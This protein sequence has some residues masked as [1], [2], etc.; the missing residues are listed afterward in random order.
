MMTV[1]ILTRLSMIT[2][3]SFGSVAFVSAGNEQPSNSAMISAEIAGITYT[4]D[5]RSIKRIKLVEGLFKGWSSGNP[6]APEKFFH[7]EGSLYDVVAGHKF[8]SWKEI[9]AFFAAEANPA[10]NL[11][12]VPERYWVSDAGVALTWIMSFTILDD[13][14]G[15]ENKGKR[16]RIMGMSSIDFDDNDLVVSEVD[17]WSM[18]DIPRSLGI[19]PQAPQA[20]ASH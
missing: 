15:P 17:Y 7:P 12:L 5:E 9:R 1:K 10:R 18:S 3:L 19:T 2:V 6:D 13:S 20:A 11:T 4:M 14:F 16:T 8:Q